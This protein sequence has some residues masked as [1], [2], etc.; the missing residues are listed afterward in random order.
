M[1]KLLIILA[2][3]LSLS[4]YSQQTNPTGTVSDLSIVQGSVCLC[5]SVDVS[6][7]FRNKAT[8]PSPSDFYIWAKSGSNYILMHTFDYND[9]YQMLATPVGNLYNDTLY[10]TKVSI[11]CGLF[12]NNGISG[13]AAIL[14]FTFKDGLLET[15]I[16]YNC[17]VGIEEY[18]ADEQTITYYNFNGQV[19]EPKQGELLIKQVGKTRI[20]V[21]IQ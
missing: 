6:F 19:V 8:L 16:V 12:S 2:V 20:K 11:P 7:I 21:L 14:P 3:G 1:K 18:S 15:L 10:H 17:T 13:S 9:I 5:D 4:V